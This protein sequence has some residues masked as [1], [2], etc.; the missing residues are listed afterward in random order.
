MAKHLVSYDYDSSAVVT[1]SD[2]GRSGTGAKSQEFYAD[3]LDV[4]CPVC[5]RMLLIVT[6]A[7]IEGT[8]AA[9][10][11]G[12]ARARAALP[13][14]EAQQTSFERKQQQLLAEPNELPD[15]MGSSVC[16]DWDV[17]VRDDKERWTV[18]R[19][20]G[21][22][23]W[24]EPAFWEGVDRFAEVFEILHARYGSRL[25]ELRPT[26]ASLQYLYGDDLRAPRKIEDLNA[27][28]HPG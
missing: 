28:L 11:A 19:Y 4:C 8:R 22:E 2:C 1:C 25:G 10:A 3:L 14:M 7:S 16:I 24:R 5:H 17:E 15:L 20:E 27:S 18:L 26:R 9:A 23:I 12:N 21:V 13:A 6:Y